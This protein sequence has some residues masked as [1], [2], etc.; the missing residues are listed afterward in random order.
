MVVE[1]NAN[2]APASSARILLSAGE[3]SGDAYAASLVRALR[4]LDPHLAFYG[5][6]GTRLREEGAT[7]FADSSKWG[8]ISIVQSLKV[9]P[10]V[11]FGYRRTISALAKLAPAPG[12]PGLFI[13]IDFGYANIRLARHAKKHGWNVL[14]FV[15]PGSWRRDRQGRDLPSLTDAISTPFEWSASLLRE[16]GGNALWFGHPI[17]Q[18]LRERF[19]DDAPAREDGRLDTIAVLPGSRDHELEENLP[20]IAQTLRAVGDMPAVTHEVEF[21]LAPHTD[22]E[23]FRSR[24]AA[25]APERSGDRFTVGDTHGVLSR[26]RAGIVCSGTATLEA[27]LLRC[28]MVVIYRVS[29]AVER[30]SKLV[31]F[32]RPKFIALPNILLDEAAVPELVQD[33]ANPESIRSHLN[34]VMLEGETRSA[35]LSAFDRLNEILGPDDAV[36]RTAE[37]AM[38]LL[39]RRA[40]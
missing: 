16:M 20:V 33:E 21:A 23:A 13:P 19:A 38:D 1:T 32:K 30:E 25:L 6:G 37:L 31:G 3:A 29:K 7:L 34:A 11:W 24:W 27:A 17:K 4:R 5:I 8:A 40:G 28:P 35:Q 22:L 9:V 12:T 26:A 14:Y 18:L 2:A 10:R 39:G 36:T 15:P